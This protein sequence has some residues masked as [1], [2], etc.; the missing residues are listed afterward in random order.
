MSLSPAAQKIADAAVTHFTEN[1]Y[2]AASLSTLADAAG[3][4]KATIY[5]HFKN[6]DELFLSVFEQSL[7]IEREFAVRCFEQESRAGE[8]YL[9]AVSERYASSPYLRL[10][11]RT[12][13]IPPI[14]VKKEVSRGYEDFIDLIGGQFLQNFNRLHP[15]STEQSAM[16]CDAY[17]GIVDSLHIE[18]LY[19][20]P[21][22]ADRRRLS[23][24]Q[25]FSMAL[26]TV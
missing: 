16:F 14:A 11:L 20:S 2:D 8:N 18:L 1:G 7:T 15:Q 13:F 9:F 19:A 26:N 5:S 6:K 10:L 22:A 25:V 12:A 21:E 3:I 4:R 23:L 17:L 24:W